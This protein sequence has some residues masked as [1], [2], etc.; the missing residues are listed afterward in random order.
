MFNASSSCA[1]HRLSLNICVAVLWGISEEQ[2]FDVNIFF[3]VIQP[4]SICKAYAVK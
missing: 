4:W 3:I 1:I 2:P